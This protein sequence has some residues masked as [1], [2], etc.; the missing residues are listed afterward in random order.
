M[1]TAQDTVDTIEH[2]ESLLNEMYRMKLSID[3]AWFK[4]EKSFADT[5]DISILEEGIS[6]II[7]WILGPAETILNSQQRVGYD[8][9]SS[10]ERRREHESLEMQCWIAYGQYAALLHKV[11]NLPVTDITPQRKDLISQRDFMDF[12]CRCFATR[13]EQ[14]RN[15]LNTSLKFFR[16]ASEYFDRT[17]EVFE[18]LLMG[19]KVQDFSSAG[20][21]LKELQDNQIRLGKYIRFLS[22]GWYGLGANIG[23]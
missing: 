13:L 4:M 17:S 6:R 9:I 2:I 22:T 23:I 14:R 15:I 21:K 10:E 16:L 3:D 5:K 19:N 8:V 11:D 1:S 7:N 12:V 18:S 20:Q